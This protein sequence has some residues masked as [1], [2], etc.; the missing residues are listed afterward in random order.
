M[1]HPF[2]AMTFSDLNLPQPILSAVEETGYTEP[3]PIQA[4]A[5][6]LILKRRDV[7]GIAQTGTGK[8]AA[9]TL[10][11]LSIL[12]AIKPKA[13]GIRA[14]IIAPTR[15]LVAQIR[16]NINDYSRHISVKVTAIYGGVG[17]QPQIEA[18]QKGAEIV[19]ATPG[20]LIDLMD[21]GHIDFRGLEMLVLD[22]ADRM[23]DMGFL[24]AMRKLARKVPND[25]QTLLFSATFSNQIETLAREF[26]QKPAFVEIGERTNPAKTVNQCVYEVPGHLKFPLLLHLLES[27]EL[28]TVLVFCKMKHATGRLAKSLTQSG[29]PAEAIHGDRTQNQRQ[30]ALD[31]FKLGKLRVLVATDV[32]ARGIDVS[33]VTHV[34][35][36]DFPLQNEDYIHRIGRTGRAKAEGD[37]ITFVTPYEQ[38]ALQDL[39]RYIRVD[40]P[41]KHSRDFDYDVP[42]P[43]RDESRRNGPRNGPPRKQGGNKPNQ[44]GKKPPQGRNKRRK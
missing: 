20:R 25:R 19:I 36:Y 43:V 44:G 23:L 10:P 33:G 24:P 13:P 12:G 14:L 8:T 3:T 41:R 2:L 29:V 27:P 11:L 31:K 1:L 22:E 32:A 9:F 30:R 37:A 4:K 7:I 26:Q 18:L 39:E 28:F 40:L 35:N 38:R 42:A 34:I 15:E 16:D 6:P 17:E 5:I 21:Q